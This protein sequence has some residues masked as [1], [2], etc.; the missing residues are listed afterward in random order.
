MFLHPACRAVIKIANGQRGKEANPA[1]FANRDLL[2]SQTL[3]TGLWTRYEISRINRRPSHSLPFPQSGSLTNSRDPCLL[4]D[5]A[6]IYFR[7]LA[8]RCHG[9]KGRTCLNLPASGKHA[10]IVNSS[11]DTFWA[12]RVQ[13]CPLSKAIRWH[14]YSKTAQWHRQCTPFQT[15]L[16]PTFP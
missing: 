1:N 8:G 12:S 10:A 16:L 15:A 2:T 7:R 3:F 4:V 11:R 14:W 13:N 5:Q 6:H 9:N